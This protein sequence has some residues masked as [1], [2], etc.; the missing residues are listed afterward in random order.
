MAG[1]FVQIDTEHFAAERMLQL[2]INAGKQSYETDFLFQENQN[3]FGITEN[4][5][6]DSL[7]CLYR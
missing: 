2:R 7:A 5:I 1:L 3:R 6:T 4:R